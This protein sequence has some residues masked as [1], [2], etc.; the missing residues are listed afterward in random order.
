MKVLLVNKYWRRQGGVEEYSFLL[1]ETLE[2]LGHEV[3]PMSQLEA[4]TEPTPWSSYFVPEV[5]PTSKSPKEQARAANRAVFGR[6][7]T[8]AVSRLLDD[9]NIGAAH[10]VHAYHQLG[11]MFMKELGRRGI[12]TVLSVHDYKLCCP[13]Y[14]LYDDSTSRV[15]TRCLDD[16]RQRV[17]APT[18]VRCW[19]G[20]RAGGALLGAEAL[21]VRIAKPYHEAGAIMV[22][23]ALMR[24]CAESA[25]LQPERVRVVP[26]FWPAS[27]A[28]VTRPR[29]APGN[30]VFV[31]RL[32]VEKGVDVLLRAAAD[33]GVSVDIV[34]DGPLRSELETLAR[35]LNAPV[36]FVGG[37]WGPDLERMILQSPA[38][39]VPST[40]HEVS[41]LVIY[42]AMSLGVP[43]IGSD[44]GGIPD[45][46]GED[47]GFL[48][49]PGDPT[50]LGAAM[51]A[52][53]RDPR[54]A[55]RRAARARR[56]SDT[57]LSRERFIQRLRDVYALAGAQL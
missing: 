17:V 6:E 27:E 32:V 16:P 19:R 53:L 35:D 22:S 21:A 51:A 52:V 15:C 13:S 24:R 44:V 33:T 34:G 31:G 41:P 39:V 7:T 23:N 38:M 28:E 4:S 10:V 2:R 43:V 1:K 3:V 18:L 47:R 20:S 49:P 8:R 5:D 57:E 55:D 29:P 9:V 54:E 42:Q 56:Y 50:T 45:L 25:G 14:R 11:P 46:L 26:N 37:V 30:I 40:W 48:V 36:R 12:P